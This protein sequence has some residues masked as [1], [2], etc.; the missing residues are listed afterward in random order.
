MNRARKQEL[1]FH[2]YT[3]DNKVCLLWDPVQTKVGQ[4][5]FL[6]ASAEVGQT[7]ENSSEFIY[8][9]KTLKHPHECRNEQLHSVKLSY[10]VL[11]LLTWRECG[12]STNQKRPQ[13]F[14]WPEEITVPLPTIRGCSS[15]TG[16]KRPQFLHRPLEAK[17]SATDLQR[18][19]FL[20]GFEDTTFLLPSR[21][22]WGSSTRLKRPQFLFRPLE[23]TVQLQTFK[24]GLCFS[25]SVTP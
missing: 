19:Q 16:L 22:D 21:K 17:S 4:F 1:W 2:V 14:Y 9:T 13:F 10:S 24:A 25:N 15:S 3:A 12:S 5:C 6:S 7:Q 11:P 18:P 20:H 8:N 23:A